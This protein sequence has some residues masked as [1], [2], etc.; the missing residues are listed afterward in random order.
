MLKEASEKSEPQVS[1]L[2]TEH[3]PHP[4]RGPCSNDPL[5]TP[6]LPP[7]AEGNSKLSLEE[8]RLKP[9]VELGAAETDEG[10][11][12]NGYLD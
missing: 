5:P 8:G 3:R 7:R 12:G 4:P 6:G 2:R 9:S 10:T 11:K 1:K